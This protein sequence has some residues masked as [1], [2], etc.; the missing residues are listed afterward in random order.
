MS[1]AGTV[2]FE[3]CSVINNHIE[4]TGTNV[5]GSYG[6]GTIAGF[7]ANGFQDVNDVDDDENTS[8]WHNGST[9]VRDCLVYGTK[10]V[11]AVKSVSGVV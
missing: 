2:V 4:S 7:V 8:E 1:G 3:K 5:N 9:I 6:A 11:S 10:V